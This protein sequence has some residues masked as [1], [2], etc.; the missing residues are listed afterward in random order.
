MMIGAR[1]DDAAQN[2]RFCEAARRGLIDY[3]EVNFP[4]TDRET[5]AA[6]EI[7]IL[8]HT[9][10]NPLAS[11][12]GIN[13][14][15]AAAVK[16]GADNANSPWVGEHLAWLGFEHQ[17]ALGYV[18]NP[19]FIEEFVEIA[20]ANVRALGEYYARPVALELAPVYAKSGTFES[21]LH[22]LNAVATRADCAI[23]LDVAHWTISNRNLAR[24]SDF[25]LDVLDLDR[26][27]EIHVAGVR[28]GVSSPY[29]HDAHALPL[30][31][32]ILALARDVGRKL[33]QLKAVTFEHAV[34]APLED[35]YGSLERLRERLAL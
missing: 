10:F 14:H 33:P 22:Y 8:A 2:E 7:P 32:D 9:S 4:V 3:A 17:G 24:A 5:P 20:V 27:I 25:G 31:D 29:W 16:Q 15:V 26:V 35:F 12:F 6:F 11:A 19:P 18:F 21:E 30:S 13:E 1:W 28:R 34:S 23:I